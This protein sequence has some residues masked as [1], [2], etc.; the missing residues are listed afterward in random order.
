M[1]KRIKA[2]LI[3]KILIV[4]VLLIPFTGQ[5]DTLGQK[6][7]FFVNSQ[8]DKYSRSQLTA[9]LRQLSGRMY[10]YVEDSYW[11]G[12]DSSRQSSLMANMLTLADEFENTIYP[13]ETLLWG[14]DPNPGV[15]GDPKIT[16]LLE[17]LI[18]NNGGYFDTSNGY[19]RQDVGSSNQ[20]EMIV[21]NVETLTS[22]VKLTKT[23]LTHEFQHLISFNQKE[24]TYNLS[25]DTWLNEA[26]AEYSVSL[27]GYND[28][29]SDSNLSRR[30]SVFLDNSSDSLVEWPNKTS[31]YG[32]AALFA[33]YLA[34]Q[35][36]SSFLAETLK[37]PYTGINSLNRY[38]QAKGHSERFTDIF[39]NWM[40]AVY[41]NDLSLDS[42]WGYKRTELKN[43]KVSPQQRILLSNALQDYS[44]FQAVKD[45]QPVWLEFD[46]SNFS[47]DISK[48]AKLDIGGDPSQNFH[49]AYVALY[50]EGPAQIGRVPVISGKGS[51]GILNS[52][53][54]LRKVAVLATKGTKTSDFLSNEAPSSLAVKLSVMDT[55]QVEASTVKD[56]ALIR[57]GNAPEIY[58]IWGKYK[59]Y[60]VPGVIAMYGHLDPADAIGVE[61]EVFHSY[62]TANYVKYVNDEKVYAVWPDETKHWLNITPQ[63]WDASGRDW[64]AIFT[65]N[66]LE[67]NYYK[68]GADIIR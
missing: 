47:G 61:P 32:V 42:R 18:K 38:L 63:Q 29:Y 33:E 10:F 59:R 36:G 67:L 39:L 23:F 46:L 53:K 52:D 54:K 21:I 13:R 66:D 51:A 55:K 25:E 58:V 24:L 6:E 49:A 56:G 68:A 8:F 20:R 11:N 16:I 19:L 15:D 31:D 3:C 48:S 35:F 28:N 64:G 44:V 17:D 40:T 30:V 45:W 57:N 50:D 22:D 12:L 62:T 43:I 9:T 37:G 5:A 4:F 1:A 14:S 2:S 26:R 65:I 60:L 34:E 27:A 41:L 7:S